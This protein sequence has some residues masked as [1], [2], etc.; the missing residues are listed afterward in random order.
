MKSV[1]QFESLAE[2][3]LLPCSCSRKEPFICYVVNILD[4]NDFLCDIIEII[5]ERAVSC[6]TEKKRISLR[7]ERF[8]LNIDS[9]SVCSLV[10]ECECNIVLHTILC[11]ISRFHFSI[12]LLEKMLMLWRNSNNKIC[13]SILVP[14]IVLSL[15]KMLCERSTDLT[16][17]ILMELENALR[18]RTISEAL[19]CKSLCKN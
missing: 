3:N 8:V 19:I 13:C 1:S 15:H 14:H 10:L 2:K 5:D 18:L 11:L 17:S 12:C 16:V 7:S 4:G 9:N 6:R